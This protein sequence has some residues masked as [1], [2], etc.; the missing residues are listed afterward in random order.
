MSERTEL[1]NRVVEEFKSRILN[2]IPEDLRGLL[3]HWDDCDMD[4]RRFWFYIS[5]P[6]LKYEGPGVGSRAK[7]VSQLIRACI[8]ACKYIEDNSTYQ[9]HWDLQES[10]KARTTGEGRWRQFSSWS[11]YTWVYVLAM[12]GGPDAVT[13][14]QLCQKR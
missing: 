1:A 14:T 2:A 11:G 9:F 12:Y 3:V 8:R 6:R 5:D 13:I 4:E 7:A 10:P